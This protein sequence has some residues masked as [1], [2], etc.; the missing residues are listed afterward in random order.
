MGIPSE[1]TEIEEE[2]EVN[3][4]STVAAIKWQ[5]ARE[6]WILLCSWWYYWGGSLENALLMDKVVAVDGRRKRVNPEDSM[7]DV[8]LEIACRVLKC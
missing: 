6:W 3:R 8:K 2:R 7:P 4:L 1:L 5:S